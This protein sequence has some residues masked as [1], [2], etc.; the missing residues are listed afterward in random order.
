VP[1]GAVPGFA[2]LQ[3]HVPHP[4]QIHRV[5][6]RPLSAVR[7]KARGSAPVVKRHASAA[8]TIAEEKALPVSRWH[9]VQWQV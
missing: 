4:A 3:T 7:S 2:P 9:T 1:G 6:V 8:T 5:T